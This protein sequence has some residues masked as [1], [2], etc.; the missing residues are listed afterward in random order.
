MQEFR[1]VEEEAMRSKFT[2]AD[3]IALREYMCNDIYTRDAPDE[4]ATVRARTI[5]GECS[6]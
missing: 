5:H 6:N 4:D 1:C 3:I 2:D